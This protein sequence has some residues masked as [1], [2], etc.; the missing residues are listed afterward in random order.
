MGLMCC[1][2]SD[3]AIR[4]GG[5]GYGDISRASGSASGCTQAAAVEAAAGTRLEALPALAVGHRRLARARAAV[6]ER[7]SAVAGGYNI[8]SAGRL[9]AAAAGGGSIGWQLLTAAHGG[10]KPPALTAA[11]AAAAVGQLHEAAQAR[12][13]AAAADGRARSVEGN[14]VGSAAA[15]KTSPQA[16]A[17]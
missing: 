2:H 13:A 15:G 3:V 11:S 12:G 8:G 1:G 17:T 5:G 6:S 7:L 9:W 16:T 10:E 14:E 4:E